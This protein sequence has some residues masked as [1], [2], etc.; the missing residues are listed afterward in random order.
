MQQEPRCIDVDTSC[1]PLYQPTFDNVYTNTL[2]GKCGSTNVSC[3]SAA[4][5]MGGM[6]FADPATAYAALLDSTKR[7]VVPGD[8]GCSR[9][10]VRTN[11]I[12][13]DYQMPP[14]APLSDEHE[15]CAM[16]LWVANGAP[17]PGVQ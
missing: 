3:H 6:S 1:A 14:G 16:I 17:G 9:I 4:G 5:H 12:G 2:Q 15:R 8:P 7:R 11:G 13:T 10:I